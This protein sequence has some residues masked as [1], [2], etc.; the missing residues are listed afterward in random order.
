MIEIQAE[1]WTPGPSLGQGGATQ[2]LRL[3]I[4]RANAAWERDD[5]ESALADFEGVLA[6]HPDFPDIRNWAGVCQAMLGRP[7]GA[8]REFDQAIRLNP[9]Y[10]EAHLNRAVILSELG[11][12]DEVG[13][14]VMRLR[15]LDAAN[16]D[17]FPPELG[18]R[19]ATD[20]GR[21]GDLYM[22][23]GR[24]EDAVEEYRKA[25]EIRPGFVDIR[26]R[27]ARGYAEMDELT[28]AVDELTLVLAEHPSFLDARI[29]LGAIL[30]RLGRR[31]EA[32]AEW[33]RCLEIDPADRR[34]RAYLI[35]A[36]VRLDEIEVAQA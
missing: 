10:A 30:Q 20:H 28:A 8:L 4:A 5:Y 22:Q 14:S 9:R 35:S 31:D 3:L 13:E 18:N 34:A 25:L 24:P 36:G 21:L 15:E 29:R 23:A 16:D 7:E 32:V 1:G 2:N 12:S 19:I 27:L 11:R 17:T 26:N 6:T 33:R